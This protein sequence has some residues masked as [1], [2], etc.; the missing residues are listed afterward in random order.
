MLSIL[1]YDL[2][3][4]RYEASKMGLDFLDTLYV[5]FSLHS[6]VIVKMAVF[7]GTR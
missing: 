5:Y 2:N 6:L 3:S 1:C 7:L 4:L